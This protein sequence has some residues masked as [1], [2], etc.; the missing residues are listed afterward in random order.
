[1]KRVVSLGVLLVAVAW[2]TGGLGE[3]VPQNDN[4]GDATPIASIPF[5][6][7]VHNGRATSQPRDLSCTPPDGHSIWFTVKPSAGTYIARA[8]SPDAPVNSDVIIAYGPAND[9]HLVSCGLYGA[10]WQA[11]VTTTYHI[12]IAE[13]SGSPGGEVDFAIDPVPLVVKVAVNPIER[14]LADGSAIVTGRLECSFP[15]I[16]YAGNAVVVVVARQNHRVFAGQVTDLT[17]CVGTTSTVWRARVQ[18]EEAH[19]RIHPGDVRFEVYGDVGDHAQ[20]GDF[21]VYRHITLR[22]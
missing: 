21:D 14:V 4:I 10:Q 13:A 22:R 9:L 8:P 17:A 16:G 20:F 15:L 2:P 6:Q 5:Y 11:D 12:E 19:R 18:G 7:V 3:T 1:M